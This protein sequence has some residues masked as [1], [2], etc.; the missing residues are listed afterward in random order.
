MF[1]ITAKDS[2]DHVKYWLGEIKKNGND[3]VP[4][5]LVGNKSGTAIVIF[6][7]TIQHYVHTFYIVIRVANILSNYC[8]VLEI[9][10]SCTVKLKFIRKDLED[11]RMVSKEECQVCIFIIILIS[12]S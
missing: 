2:F 5:V 6:T 7:L 12:F 9:Y 11:K 8:W 1:D 4:K 3:F 10:L